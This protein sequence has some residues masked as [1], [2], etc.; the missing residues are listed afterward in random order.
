MS[1]DR[2]NSFKSSEENKVVLI[3]TQSQSPSH[4]EG[5]YR[6]K[7]SESEEKSNPF[8]DVEFAQ[9]KTIVDWDGPDDPEN[10][11]NWKLWR[12]LVVTIL[13]SLTTTSLYMGAAIY[14]PAIP[15]IIEDMHVS[16]VKAALGLTLFVWGYGIGSLWFSPMSEIPFFRGRN[17]TYFACQFIFAILQIPTALSNHIGGFAVLR[18][19]G[20]IF[21]S[22]PLSTAGATLGDIWV[23]PAYAI[24]LIFWAF[25]AI[26]GPFLGPLIGGA[27]VQGH[28]RHYVFWFM[29][30]V[31]GG[32]FV[33]MVLLLPETSAQELLTRKARRLRKET[34]NPDIV[35]PG[36]IINHTQTARDII[37]LMFFKPIEMT[38]MEPVL[39]L[40]DLHLGLVYSLMYLYFEAFP[41]VYQ[42][43]YGFNL[44]EQGCAYL[45]LLIGSVIGCITY[46]TYMGFAAPRMTELEKLFSL[47]ATFGAFLL[48]VGI[49]VFGW[50]ARE[51]FNWAVSMVGNIFFA[52]AAFFLF[53]SYFGFIGNM[54]P[55]SAVGSAFAS[56]NI[57][58]SMM[59]GAF[60]LFGTVMYNHTA[61]DK[62][63]VGWGCTILGIV[64]M[65]LIPLPIYLYFR[66]KSLR[67]YA[68]RKYGGKLH[69]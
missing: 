65:M 18:F 17:P 69:R 47:S 52:W 10:P 46:L 53:Q 64:G 12:K 41:I 63:P 55:P 50:C 57:V 67:E 26:A 20:G 40:I 8:A 27:L 48:P 24:A 56:N 62:Y 1:F 35:S 45:S 22:P 38:I 28:N 39:L 4:L 36:E 51:G 19:L 25:G 59:G 54:Y 2:S 13:I 21:A 44:V 32:M 43:L 42:G 7:E 23:I 31:S 61:I 58:R 68:Q 15:E 11:H 49:L 9:G 33:L 29:L 30:A 37:K 6:D 5:T 66:G 14:T 16:E 34:G 3:A 60:P